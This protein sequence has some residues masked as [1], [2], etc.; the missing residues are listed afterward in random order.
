MQLRLK[1]TYVLLAT[2]FLL[3]VL[4]PFVGAQPALAAAGDD[5]EIVELINAARTKAGLAPLTYD[6]NL[7]VQAAN[8]LDTYLTTGKS[9]SST[10]L[11]QIAKNGGYSSLGQAVLSGKDAAAIAQ[12]QIKYYGSQTVLNSKY[13]TIGLVVADTSKGITCLQLLATKPQAQQSTKPTQPTQPT[14]PTKPQQPVQQPEQ[15]PEQPVEQQSTSFMNTLQQQ[16]V[17][18]VNVERAKYSL[19][20]LVA[21][22]DLTAVAQ[23]KAQ[24]MYNSRYFSHQSPNYGSPFDMMKKYGISYRAAGEN[25]AMG[26]RTAA[27]VVEDWMNSPGHRANILNT[28]YNE[29]GVGVYQSYNGYGYIWVQEFA[30]R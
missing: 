9:P 29:I 11:T 23:L 14:Q 13:N 27:Q 15:K 10:T 12:A 20:P 2:L 6:V 22:Q 30:R 16:V 24:D 21:K 1:R 19:Q 17:D 5:Q 3:S 4:I 28:N 7:S 25:I 26:Q 18:L 8:N